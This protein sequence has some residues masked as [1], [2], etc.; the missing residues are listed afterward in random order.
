MTAR[1]PCI[2][3]DAASQI[4]HRAN[5]ASQILT[6]LRNQIPMESFS[7]DDWY[8]YVVET[9]E[10]VGSLSG[11]NWNKWNLP[12]IPVGHVLAKGMTA[13]HQMLWRKK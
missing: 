3:F 7:D 6:E 13:K 5:V 11:K 12:E 9:G 2:A 1:F 4:E 10:L 8:E